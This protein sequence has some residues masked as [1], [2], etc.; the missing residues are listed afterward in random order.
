[1]KKEALLYEKLTNKSVHCNL[2]AHRCTIADTKFGLC[3][4][5]QNFAGELFTHAYGE[6]IAA[7]I[8]PIEKKPLYHFLPGSFA[9]SMAT[10][11]C[12]FKCSFCQNLVPVSS[13]E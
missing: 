4:V 3:G 8:D 12:N 11:G 10:I 13:S 9:F 5:R 6:L 1:M 2:C 7:H